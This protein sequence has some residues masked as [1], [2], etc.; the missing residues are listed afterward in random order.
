[1]YLVYLLKPIVS[2][3]QFPIKIETNIGKNFDLNRFKKRAI[4][5]EYSFKKSN[6][7]IPPF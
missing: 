7:Y 5:P 6:Q 4:L 3:D 1:M 2:N